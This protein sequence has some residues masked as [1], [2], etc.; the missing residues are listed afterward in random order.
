MG[1]RLSS[2]WR[3]ANYFRYARTRFAPDALDSHAAAPTTPAGWSR[4]RRRRPPPPRSAAPRPSPR[5]PK[6]D[7]TPGSSSCAPPGQSVTITNQMLNQLNAPVEAAWRE[8]DEA[9]QAAAAIPA[10]WP[11]T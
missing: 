11:R 7:G 2:R 1:W 9:E 5:P 4:T 8:L 3:E 10:T 6:P